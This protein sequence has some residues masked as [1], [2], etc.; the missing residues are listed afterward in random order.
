ML[1]YREPIRWPRLTELIGSIWIFLLAK[2]GVGR[3]LITTFTY[4]LGIVAEICFQI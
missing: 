3:V 1:V 4:C 2:L